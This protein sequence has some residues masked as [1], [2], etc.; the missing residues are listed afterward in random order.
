MKRERAEQVGGRECGIEM[1]RRER[2]RYR[3]K[4]EGEKG[5]AREREG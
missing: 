5:G 4:M 3:D 2:G 1:G